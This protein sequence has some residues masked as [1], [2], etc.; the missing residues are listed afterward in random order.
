MEE[1]FKEALYEKL[2]HYEANME[3]NEFACKF[4]YIKNCLDNNNKG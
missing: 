1:Q 4:N 2:S 3:F